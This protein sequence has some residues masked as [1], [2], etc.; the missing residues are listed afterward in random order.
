LRYRGTCYRAHNP[1]WAFKP[2][3]GD[4]AA[5]Y[6][7]RFN[8]KGKPALYLALDIS[9]AVLEANQGFAHKIDPCTLCAYEVDCG[10]IADL[11]NEA[12]R[13]RHAATR[14]DIECA[15]LILAR[16]GKTPPSW[17]I[18]TR[19]IGEGF[20]GVLVRSLA[21]RSRAD[22]YNLV[23]W[24]WGPDRPHRVTV[25]DPG[26]KLPKNQLSWK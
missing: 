13:K 5:L 11:R 6:G 23:L 22:A 16:A 21:R 25:S 24:R 26:G 17:A 14:A 1:A 4:G 7:G 3:S 19:L 10:D 9:T 8:P 18:A 15:W 12:G 2:L 20:A